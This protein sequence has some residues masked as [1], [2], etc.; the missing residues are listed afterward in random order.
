M[1]LA[2]TPA[3][4]N[5]ILGAM[6]SVAAVHGEARVTPADRASIAAAR[7]YLFRQPDPVE[8]ADLPNV[9]PAELRTLL[10]D[11]AM[12][13]QAVRFLTV[14]AFVDGALDAGKIARVLEFAEA[15]GVREPY[16][17]EIT[18]AAQGEVHAALMDMTRMNLESITG[19]PA[20]PGE[21]AMAWFVPY[22]AAP[23]PALAARFHALE[24]LP[25]DSFGRTFWAFYRANG[26]AFPGEPDG[27]NQG[28]AVPHDSTHV[29]AGYDTS[30]RGEIL[31][32]TFTA[33][34][35][36]K[37]PMAGHVLPVIFSWHLGVE[38]NEI[39]RSA[40]GA[41]DPEAFW[42]A[43]ARGAAIRQDLFAPVWN[44]WTVVEETVAELRRRY[45]IPPLTAARTG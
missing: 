11:S 6:R 19:R 35:H 38:I 8:P 39:A 30:P 14:M 23:D 31:V 29:L 32:S 12:A 36:P 40:R 13:E 3:Q 17:A 16:V 43:W 27:L 22:R 42:E 5:A 1:D 21:D 28:F 9:A 34:M 18:Q 44:F 25:P 26:Y 41:L 33:A 20:P 4:M 37:R 2:T 24:A 45:G 7:R 15:L 10:P